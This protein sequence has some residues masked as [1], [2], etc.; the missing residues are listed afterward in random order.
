MG[1]RDHRQILEDGMNSP[2]WVFAAWEEIERKIRRA[3][4]LALFTD[5]DGTLVRIRSHP[6]GVR[7][8]PAVI[9]LLA[10]M[11]RH[12]VVGIASGRSAVDLRKR[13]HVPHVWQISCH[14]FFLRS[15]AGRAVSLLTPAE[16]R[17]IRWAA[18]TLRNRLGAVPG[19]G[20]EGKQAS[21]AVHYRRSL[22]GSRQAAW[23]AVCDVLHARPSF[24]LLRGKKVWEI[25][26]NARVD[27]WTAIRYALDR[28]RR[29]RAGGRWL[30]IYLGDDAT[31]ERV[32]RRMHGISIA[33]GKRR[34]TA[35]SYFVRSPAEARRF[36]ER[37]GEALRAKRRRSRPGWSTRPA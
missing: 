7:L 6:A 5:F 8:S 35:A 21:I 22:P 1:G 15:P 10:G 19:I 3:D 32:F 27:K 9:R 25:L 4:R 16:A 36:L 14:G 24:H 26:P 30:V 23:R 37:C 18:R 29:R 12:H 17:R 28:E 33:V 20:L 2:R 31:D 34:R 11:A 13:A